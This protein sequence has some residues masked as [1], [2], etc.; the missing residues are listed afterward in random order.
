MT[1]VSEQPGNIAGR[2]LDIYADMRG[3]KQPHMKKGH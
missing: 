1:R 2:Q 3:I